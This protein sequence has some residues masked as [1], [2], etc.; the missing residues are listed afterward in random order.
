MKSVKYLGLVLLVMTLMV[1]GGLSVK[2]EG[3]IDFTGESLNEKLEAYI[4]ERKE[5]TASVSIAAFKEGEIVT[6]KQAGYIDVENQIEA[7]ANSIYEWGSVSK[8]LTWVAVMQ[9]VEQGKID[10]E[11]PISEYLP[12]VFM[13]KMNFKYPFTMKDVMNHQAGFQEVAYKEEFGQEEQVPDLETL[14][15]KNQP[16]QVYQPGSYT[17]YSN[18]TASLA[19][20]VVESLTGQPF[21][22]YV[23]QNIFDRLGMKHTSIK[24]DWSDNPFV[25]EGRERSKAYSYTLESKESMG[26]SIAHVGVYPAGAAAGTLADFAVFCSQFTAQETPLFE[27]VETL[28]QMKK[29][30][31]N[32]SNHDLGRIYHG[33]W[34]IDA[35]KKVLG[36]PGNTQGFSSSFWF[37]PE[38]NTGF[39]VMT[40]EVGETSYNYGL[41]ELIYGPYQGE[42]QAE[43]DVAGLYSSARTVEQGFLRMIKYFSALLPISG[44]DQEGVFKMSLGNMPIKSL[45]DGVYH[46][47][48]GNGRDHLMIYDHDQERFESLFSDYLKLSGLQIGLSFG[49]VLYLLVIIVAAIVKGVYLLIKKLRKKLNPSKFAQL[50]RLGLL[51]SLGIAI[52]FFYFWLGASSYEPIRVM[53]LCLLAALL[54]LMIVANFC[55]QLYNRSKQENQPRDLITACLYLPALIAVIFFQLYNFWS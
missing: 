31:L 18:W 24:P 25:Q 32:Y 12:Q 29:A 7:D 50:N 49:L 2:A 51:A 16:A 37:D 39:V 5:A 19:G 30:S 23:N 10:L 48:D 53:F 52:L 4:D 34:S 28:N 54:A 36:H 15:I 3:Q 47:S 35:G 46:M 43:D 20:Y 11:Q 21:Y 14:L 9:L 13:A 55:Y 26:A 17:A 27:K 45:G 38:S 42:I 41:I 44:T 1:G 33:L 40:N 22:Q 6:E 8:V